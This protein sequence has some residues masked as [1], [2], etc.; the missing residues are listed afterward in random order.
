MPKHP[1]FKHS[2][3]SIHPLDAEASVLWMPDEAISHSY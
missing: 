1:F 3:L 2:F